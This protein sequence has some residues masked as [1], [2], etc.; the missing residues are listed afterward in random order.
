MKRSFR[1]K[2]REA[3][4]K[5][6]DERELALLP[7]GFQQIGK[8]VILNLEKELWE[9]KVIIAKQVKSMVSNCDSVC[10]NVGSITGQYRTPEIELL[11]GKTTE[12]LHKEHGT[13]YSLD[14]AKIMFSKGNISERKRIPNLVSEGEIVFDFFAGIGYFSLN[15]ARFASPKQIYAFELNPISFHYL[16]ENIEL[17]KL[18]NKITPVLGDCNQEAPK[19]G[20][21][22]D[23][24]I[25]GILPAP[26]ESLPTAFQVLSSDDAFIHYEGLLAENTKEDLLLHDVVTEAEKLERKVELI[27]CTRVK[28][29]KPHVYHV[30]LDIS[31]K[32]GKLVVPLNT[33]A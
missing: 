21:K 12:T 14:C 5:E 18:T 16:K 28:S 19:V 17:N 29:F 11:L 31:V 33:N 10:L 24:I 23:R 6:L 8:V 15:I 26:K 7:R 13:L 25:M 30:C 27:K 3:L 1:D 2:L 9:K 22:A 32:K 4:Q 20:V